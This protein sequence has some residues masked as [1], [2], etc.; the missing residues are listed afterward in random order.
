[1]VFRKTNRYIIV[2]YVTSDEAQ[3]RIEFG[4]NSKELLKCGWPKEIKGSLKS[5]PAAY[6][7]GFLT[8]K[9]ITNKKLKVPILDFG[10]TRTIHK[11]NP[12]AFIKGLVDYGI[13]IKHKE[14]TFPSEERLQG[15]HIKDIKVEEIK[16]E[17]KGK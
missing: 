14:K 4:V 13:K 17:I 12:H 9:K 1:M 11:S 2:Q 10:M 15:K 3:D 5:T 6:L 16:S 7:L 8:G